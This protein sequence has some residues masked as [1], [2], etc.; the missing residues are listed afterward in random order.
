MKLQL[1]RANNIG[2]GEVDANLTSSRLFHVDSYSD[3]EQEDRDSNNS[4]EYDPLGKKLQKRENSG[5]LAPKKTKAKELSK[6]RHRKSLMIVK[7]KTPLVNFREEEDGNFDKDSE[8]EKES[9]IL[10]NSSESQSSSFSEPTA[11]KK[12]RKQPTLGKLASRVFIQEKSDLP[13]GLKPRERQMSRSGGTS[14]MQSRLKRQSSLQVPTGNRYSYLLDSIVSAVEAFGQPFR[15]NNKFLLFWDVLIFLCIVV[16]LIWIPLEISLQDVQVFSSS[17]F[18]LLLFVQL[19]YLLDIAVNFSRTYFDAQVKEVT[20]LSLIRMRYFQSTDFCV[21]LFACA[22]L[23]AFKKI[24]F[25]PKGYN[26]LFLLIRIV[27][28]FKIK[29]LVVYF[30]QRYFISSR[31][32]FLGYLLSILIIVISVKIASS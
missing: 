31:A 4:E 14:L 13:S 19:C 30:H 2:I 7:A 18:F 17:S 12:F 25:T 10:D 1:R 6:F 15:Y 8:S 16:D 21:D 26:Q 24:F 23:L 29:K 9:G 27:K 28:S 11:R 20:E 3:K 22:P 32:Y 5:G